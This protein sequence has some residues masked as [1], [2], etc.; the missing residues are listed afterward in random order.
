MCTHV[1]V[2]VTDAYSISVTDHDVYTDS[3][4]GDADAVVYTVIDVH[5]D[6]DGDAKLRSG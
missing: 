4:S 1:G 3:N 5:T 2:S 6:C